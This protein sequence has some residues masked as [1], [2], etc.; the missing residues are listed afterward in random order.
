MS[1]VDFSAL[2]NKQVDTTERPKSFPVGN[3]QAVIAGHEFGTSTKKGTPFVRF[4]CKLTGP[5]EDVD[6]EIFEEV[7]GMGALQARKPLR[8]DFYLTDDAM[9]RLREFLEDSLELQCAGRSFD[10]VIPEA[11]NVSFTATIKHD[12]GTKP[13]ET[14]MNIDDYAVAA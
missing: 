2:L 10:E 6:E 11:T 1:E 5:G 3:Y 7:G 12:A 4:F 14:Y 8:L 13:G 9:Y